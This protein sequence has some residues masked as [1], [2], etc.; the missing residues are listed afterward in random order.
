MMSEM[1]PTI[2]LLAQ[3]AASEDDL[4]VD[5]TAIAKIRGMIEEMISKINESLAEF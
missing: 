1:A 5:P 4:F 2:T 3:M